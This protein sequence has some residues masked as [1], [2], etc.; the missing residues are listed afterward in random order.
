M[1]RSWPALALGATLLLSGHTPAQETPPEFSMQKLPILGRLFPN[2]F[3]AEKVRKMSE[4]VEILTRLLDRSMNHLDPHRIHVHGVG[5]NSNSGLTGS[6]ALDRSPS[7]NGTSSDESV[8]FGSLATA[9]ANDEFRTQTKWPTARHPNLPRGEGFYLDQRGVV[10]SLAAPGLLEAPQNSTEVK[11][12]KPISDWEWTRRMLAGEKVDPPNK[13]AP[14]RK[15]NALDLIAN[16]LAENGQHLSLVPLDETVTVVVSARAEACQACHDLRGSNSRRS[17]NSEASRPMVTSGWSLPSSGAT[18]TLAPIGTTPAGATP[19]SEEGGP[20]KHELMGDL[21]LNQHQYKEALAA[22]A[23]ALETQPR[24][25]AYRKAAQAALAQA[26]VDQAQQYLR[27]YAELKGTAT[28]EQARATK[29]EKRI[30]LP[31]RLYVVASKRLLDQVGK[32][33]IS[34]EEF[35]KKL[36]V[37]WMIPEADPKPA[38]QTGNPTS[39]H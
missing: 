19:R 12:Q 1:T 22:Y 33:E 36:F 20:N 34:R 26:Q 18:S 29:K 9:N 17:G 30:P 11:E 31:A 27:K 13:S 39:N 35:R 15:I 5:V 37:E 14:T 32:G 16:C 6:I 10:I 21:H 2:N 23:K 8:L 38:A 25:E 4:E 7:L 3:S 24:P 28:T